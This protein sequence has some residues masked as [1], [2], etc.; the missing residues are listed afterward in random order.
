MQIGN[1]MALD[2]LD[3]FDVATQGRDVARLTVLIAL[4]FLLFRRVGL[5]CDWWRA[6]GRNQEG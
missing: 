5:Y 3:P 2:H 4:C 6:R 1:G